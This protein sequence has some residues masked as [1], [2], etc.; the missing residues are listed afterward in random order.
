MITLHKHN[1][2]AIIKDRYATTKYLFDFENEQSY[3][4][5]LKFEITVDPDAFIS[6]FIANI[7]GE[8]FIGKTKEKKTAAKEYSVAKQ[9]DENAILISQPHK[10]IPNVFQIKTNIGSKSKI[11]LQKK[12]I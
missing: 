6:E 9:K 7:D 12:E 1:I 4:K 2:S 10:D 3:A 8:L 11:S 5:E